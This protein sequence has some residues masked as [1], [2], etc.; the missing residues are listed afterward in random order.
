MP[1]LGTIWNSGNWISL[2]MVR[3]V[4]RVVRSRPRWVVFA[5][6]EAKL[7]FENV[8]TQQVQPSAL[9]ALAVMPYLTF[10]FYPT[11][12]VEKNGDAFCDHTAFAGYLV[13]VGHGLKMTQTMITVYSNLLYSVDLRENPMFTRVKQGSFG[14][15]LGVELGLRAHVDLACVEPAVDHHG[16][17]NLTHP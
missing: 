10:N 2:I 1:L 6:P 4:L 13:A 16:P 3:R 15:E 12:M 17:L 9:W 5:P 14:N 11:V 7:L 8:L